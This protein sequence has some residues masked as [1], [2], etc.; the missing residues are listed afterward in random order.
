MVAFLELS[1]MLLNVWRRMSVAD[2]H[3]HLSDAS[4][5]M[6]PADVLDVTG[7]S[8]NPRAED[9]HV[10]ALM[11]SICC[12]SVFSNESYGVFCCQMHCVVLCT[13]VIN[14]SVGV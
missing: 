2:E 9:R 4:Q 1:C 6:M 11:Y 14:L 8:L 10:Y 13:C 7:N 3:T 12:S 5:Q